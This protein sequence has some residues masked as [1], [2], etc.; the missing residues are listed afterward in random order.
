MPI[1]SITPPVYPTP[2]DNAVTTLASDYTVGSPT[3]TVT[4]GSLFGSPS[5]S[6]PLRI[7]CQRLSDNA[8]VHFKVTGVSGNAL[9]LAGVMDGYSDINLSANDKVGV[10]VSGGTIKD[11]QSTTLD[12]ISS[13]NTVIT[14]I[15]T[16]TSSLS[17]LGTAA[18]LAAGSANGVATLDSGGKVP[19]SQLPAAVVNGLEFVGT[20]NAST[21]S[22][23]LSS[24]VGTKGNL[25]KVSTSGTTTLDGISQ[26]NAG[27]ML[28]FDGTTWD[29]IDGLPSEVISVAG[30]TGAVTLTTSDVSGAAVDS[31]VVH[32]SGTETVSGT[33]T[34][35]ALPVLTGLNG[36]VKASSG[37]LSAASAGTDYL[38]PTGSGASLTGITGSQISGN[39]SGNASNVTGTVAVVNGGNGLTTATLGD[40]RYGSG[41]NTL[42]ALA[43]NTSTTKKFL[44]QTGTGSASAAPSWGVL[45]AA[46]IPNITESQVTNLTTDLAA[47]APLASPTFTG[48]VKMT[49]HYG[50]ITADTDGATVTFDCSVSDKH[51][52]TLAGNRTLAVTGDQIGQTILVILKQDATGSRTVTWWSGILWSSGSAPVLTTTAN[53]Q[54]VFTFIKTA[55]GVYLGFT[56]GL[57]F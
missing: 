48:Q 5:T 45:V 29:K 1:S 8:R 27:D 35:S 17:S 2:L 16:N 13:V 34:F 46:D 40:I 24:G 20:W 39:I 54:D 43:G 15:N 22:P 41:A 49:S 25:Y 11:V 42:A 56:A 52:V 31:T 3:V 26:W 32:L 47:K 44:T 28:I 21:N 14:Q 19:T 37:V 30:R 4:D 12:I 38:T 10:L 33:K 55:S 9:T 18:Y 57:N 50:D 6:A 53:K 36:L 7:T 23:A 51:T